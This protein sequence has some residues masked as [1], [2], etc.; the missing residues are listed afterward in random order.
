MAIDFGVGGGMMLTGRSADGVGTG[1]AAI[2]RESEGERPI[3]P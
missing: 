1:A 3:H 2:A